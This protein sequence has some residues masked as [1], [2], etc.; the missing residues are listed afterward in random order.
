MSRPTLFKAWEKD[1][2]TLH[3]YMLRLGLRHWMSPLWWVGPVPGFLMACEFIQLLSSVLARSYLR[4]LTQ[5]C[6]SILYYCGVS[7]RNEVLH[8]VNTVPMPCKAVLYNI[9]R[10]IHD[11]CVS[12]MNHIIIVFLKPLGMCVKLDRWRSSVR[13]IQIVVPG[14]KNELINHV[15][16]CFTP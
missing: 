2:S 5:P 6:H 13:M 3:L 15:F 14:L 10:L 9:I 4:G 12:N 11:V 16:H 7:K 8:F 1:P